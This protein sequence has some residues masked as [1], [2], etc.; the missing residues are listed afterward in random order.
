MRI[1]PSKLDSFRIYKFQIFEKS[2]EQFIRELVEGKEIT[3]AMA[4]GTAVHKFFETG[5]HGDIYPDEIYQ[6]QPYRN[7]WK[8]RIFEQEIW[9]EFAG[10]PSLMR[11]DMMHGNVIED[12]KVSGRFY[13]VDFYEKS[14]QWKMYL[15]AT[16]AARFAYH[17]FQRNTKRPYKFNYHT[18]SFY[19]YEGMRKEIDDLMEEFVYFITENGIEL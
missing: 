12:I 15:E 6:L 4:Y 10:I 8:D 18:F 11:I 2:K 7:K 3:E 17:V 1:S 9:S 13:G 14:I 5:E 19:P 16:G